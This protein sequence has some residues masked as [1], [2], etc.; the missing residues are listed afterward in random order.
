MPATAITG[1]PAPSR[2]I[3]T[4]TGSI[5]IYVDG[6]PWMEY[7]SMHPLADHFGFVRF[8]LGCGRTHTSTP[9][10]YR[11]DYCTECY[12]DRALRLPKK[13][14]LPLSTVLPTGADP[15]AEGEI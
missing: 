11:H 10:V 12:R 3:T 4:L 7:C 2:R 5:M 14:V 15:Y 13:L 9:W 8:C 1:T 6:K